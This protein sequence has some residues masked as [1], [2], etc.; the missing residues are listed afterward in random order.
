MR[1][2]ILLSLLA[3]LASAGGVAASSPPE[4]PQPIRGAGYELVKNWDFGRTIETL[5]ELRAEFHTRYVYEGGR[6]DTLPGNAEWQRYRDN[7]NHRLVGDDLQLVAHLR[8][9]M[10]DG[11]IESGLLRSKWTGKYGY[12]EIRMKVPP[13][14]GMWPAFWLNPED[15][16][17]PPEIDVVEIVNNG[18]DD[19][20][21]SF[22]NV[23]PGT[24]GQKAP[25]LYSRLDRWGSWRPGIDYK[26][27]Y[28][29]FAAEWT[30]EVVRHFVDDVLVAERRFRWVHDDGRDAGPAHVL[31][32]LAVGGKWPE[33]PQSE[34][35]FP[36]I[37]HVDWVRVWQKK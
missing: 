32:N 15:Q 14:R 1:R 6:L 11:G 7:D 4:M 21:N 33:A 24:R 17:W 18:R 3:L 10:K 19:T 25:K 26:D 31:V 37:L 35:D 29:R 8:G 9:G 13:G 30:P 2:L 34:A 5:E 20:R 22:H 28:H 27:G 16:L 36:A 23:H 12:Y